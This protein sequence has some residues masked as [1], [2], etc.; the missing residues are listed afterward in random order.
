MKHALSCLLLLSSSPPLLTQNTTGTWT[1]Y[2]PQSQ[3]YQVSIDPPINADGS[4]V[5]SYKSAIPVQY[6]QSKGEKK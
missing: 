6:A 3:T 4:S 2:P 5:W 1:L